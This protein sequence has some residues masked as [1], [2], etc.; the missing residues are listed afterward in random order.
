MNPADL[1]SGCRRRRLGATARPHP[2]QVLSQP[3]HRCFGRKGRRRPA[4]EPRVLN[5]GALVEATMARPIDCERIN[6][7]GTG[8]GSVTDAGIGIA[9]RTFRSFSPGLA[10]SWPCK[11]FI[12][13]V[14]VWA[15]TG[16][17]SWRDSLE[18]RDHRCFHAQVAGAL[19]RC[20]CRSPQ[21]P[22]SPQGGS[23]RSRPPH[24]RNAKRQGRR[25]YERR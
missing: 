25:G 1:R 10:E 9:R 22:V 16:A 21:H 17:G 15:F 6:R 19:S 7:G 12:F 4:L 13:Q 3:G 11:R 20:T 14:Q 8:R 24:A 23:G 5:A 2:G 18:P